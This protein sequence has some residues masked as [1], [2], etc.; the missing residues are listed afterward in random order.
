M[1]IVLISREF[2]NLAKRDKNVSNYQKDF[3]ACRR[4]DVILYNASFYI[5]MQAFPRTNV[6]ILNK[7]LMKYTAEYV[8][9]ILPCFMIDNPNFNRVV[10]IQ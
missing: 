1:L 10:M 2:N 9:N 3:Q 5:S 8:K 7:D 6:A 4:A